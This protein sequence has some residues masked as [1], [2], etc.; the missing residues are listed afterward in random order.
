M[1]E[2]RCLGCRAVRPKA[3]LIRLAAS[4]DGR[5][6]VDGRAVL[7]GRGAYLCPSK[8]CLEAAC[9]RRGLFARALKREGLKVPPLEDLWQEMC[10]DGAVDPGGEKDSN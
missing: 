10:G 8:A 4:D 6:V 9:A 5:L 3:G 2:R 7:R 1:P